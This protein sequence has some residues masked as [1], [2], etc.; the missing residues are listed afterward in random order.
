MVILQNLDFFNRQIGV[1]PILFVPEHLDDL[2]S[3][4]IQTIPHDAML[5]AVFYTVRQDD[6]KIF[7]SGRVFTLKQSGR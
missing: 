7:A 2:S 4:L 6:I 5:Y 1:F 3:E